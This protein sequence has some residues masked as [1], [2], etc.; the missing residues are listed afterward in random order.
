MRF[1]LSRRLFSSL[2]P[3]GILFFPL[4]AFGFLS[5]SNLFFAPCLLLIV[6]PHP[7]STPLP[8]QNWTAEILLIAPL[9]F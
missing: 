9:F 7:L 2:L 4:S 8:R 6:F 1:T 5:V 3:K